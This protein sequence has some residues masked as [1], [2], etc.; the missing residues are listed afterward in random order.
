MRQ[1]RNAAVATAEAEVPVQPPAVGA[2]GVASFAIEARRVPPGDAVRAAGDAEQRLYEVAISSEAEIE[3]WYGIEVLEHTAEAVD[4]TRLKDGA[5]V[6]VDHWSDQVGVVERAWLDKDKKLRGLLRFS[7]SQRGQDIERDIDERIRRHISVGYMVHAVV[8]EDRE[9]GKDDKGNPIVT[10]VYRVV[11]WEPMEVSVVSVPADMTVGVG[12]NAGAVA[13]AP[14]GA[15]PAAPAEGVKTM[16]R[17]RGDNGTVVEVADD[18]PRPAVTDVAIITDQRSET[19]QQRDRDRAEIIRMCDGYGRGGL[20]AGYIEQGLT[21]DQVARDLFNLTRT[22]PPTRAPGPPELPLR[23]SDRRRYSYAAAIQAGLA[24]ADN[25]RGDGK[26]KKVGG[27]EIE[28]H[29]QLVRDYGPPPNGGILLPYDLRTAEQRWRDME[30][31]T[32]DS[33]VATKG[34]E[35]VFE[36]AGQ[37]IELLRNRTVVIALG[38]QVMPGLVG[39]LS[40]PKQTS[41]GTAYWV[42]ENPGADVTDSDLGLGLVN[43]LGKTLQGSQ[44][45]TR[46]LL[47]QSAFDLEGKVRNDLSAIHARAVDRAAIHGLSAAGQPTGIY[48]TPNVNSKPHGGAVTYANLIDQ[49]VQ[50]AEDNADEGALGWITT[51]GMAGKLKTK[52][53]HD[54]ATMAG[55]IWQGNLRDGTIDG[56]RARATA[57]VSKTMSGTAE[58]GGAE[59][60]IIFGNWNDLVLGMWGAFEIVVDPYA[61]KKQAIIELTSYQLVDIAVLHAESFSVATGATLA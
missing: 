34:P 10:P 26:G 7:S 31:R 54:T 40:F 2:R 4:M 1:V 38:A 17:V 25:D 22:P 59:H 9:T 13:P 8:R 41:A 58:G 57:Q 20:A 48:L 61:K 51:P 24:Q 28:V 56:Y 14:Q 60:G 49:M 12:R 55:W 45:Y 16:K 33:K 32:L 6:L 21:A 18:D 19:E 47:A 44:S 35:V 39:P 11:R 42:G 27:L 5:A 53:E 29:Q 37:F 46:Q 23:E 36:Q 52:A 43:M 3:R 30:R 15:A 50:V